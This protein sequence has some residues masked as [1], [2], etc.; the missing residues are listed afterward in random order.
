MTF[1][2]TTLTPVVRAPASLHRAALSASPV[3]ERR[4]FTMNNDTITNTTRHR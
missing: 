1:I 3:V 4:K 2:W